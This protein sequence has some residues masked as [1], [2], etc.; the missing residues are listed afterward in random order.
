VGPFLSLNVQF[1]VGK[2][3]GSFYKILKA[4]LPTMCGVKFK[5]IGGIK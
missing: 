5:M 3:G 1:D 4:E 2:H